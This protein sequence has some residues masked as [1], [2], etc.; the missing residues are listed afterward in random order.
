[1]ESR[2]QRSHGRALVVS[3]AVWSA[4]ELATVPLLRPSFLRERGERERV[5]ASRRS[6]ATPWRSCMPSALTCRARDGVRM[7]NVAEILPPVGHVEGDDVHLEFAL[8]TDR[9]TLA[10]IIVQTVAK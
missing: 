9:G 2:V 7:L 4:L 8:L 5:D 3:D 1:M 6:R 10:S